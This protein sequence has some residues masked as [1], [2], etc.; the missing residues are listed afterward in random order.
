VSDGGVY[1]ATTTSG[2]AALRTAGE[3]GAGTISGS[4]L[5]VS[6][7]DTNSEFSK[8]MAAQQA[9]SGAAQ[10]MSAANSMFDTLISA[11]R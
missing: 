10:V 5:E 2:N 6:T 1:Y 3:S 7:T 4:R 9:Y 8:M 11:V